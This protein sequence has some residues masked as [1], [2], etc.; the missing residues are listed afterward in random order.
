MDFVPEYLAAFK[1]TLPE[2]VGDVDQSIALELLVYV[3]HAGRA[4]PLAPDPG[5]LVPCAALDL[6]EDLD[7]H[8]EVAGDQDSEGNLDV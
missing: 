8:G 5:G 7:D 3:L 6:L 2:R 1:I 4:L